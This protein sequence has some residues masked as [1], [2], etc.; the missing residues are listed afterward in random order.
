M[1]DFR[2]FLIAGTIVIVL[3]ILSLVVLENQYPE[4]NARG[5]WGDSFG[6]LN[7]LFS[8]LAFSGIIATIIMQKKELELQREE[9]KSTRKELENSTKAQNKTQ[10]A[11]NTQVELMAIQVLLQSYQNQKEA[12][13]KTTWDNKGMNVDQKAAMEG[14]IMELAKSIN[15]LRD[16]IERIRAN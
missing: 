9:L 1:K 13:E 14:R 16:E 10:E 4:P 5:V 11:L 6:G 2:P 7:A 15:A 12:M 3:W 8:G